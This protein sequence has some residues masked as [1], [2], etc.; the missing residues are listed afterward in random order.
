[1]V[2]WNSA[3]TV[4]DDAWDLAVDARGALYVA[5][6][7]AVGSAAGS[8]WALRR[9]TAAGV[10]DATFG[11]AGT[12]TWDSGVN[13]QDVLAQVVVD[14]AGN[15]YAGGT[16]QANGTD[17]VVRKYNSSGVLCD[18]LG[19]CPNWG[20]SGMV[21]YN[22]SGTVEDQLTSLALAPTGQLY[23]GGYH[24]GTGYDWVVRR[25]TTAG[26]LDG[27]WATAGTLTWSS[28]GSVNDIIS[29]GAITVDDAGNVF[30]AG[31]Q[32]TGTTDIAV[33]KYNASGVPCDGLGACPNWG[34]S[35]MVTY[36][37]GGGQ[38]SAYGTALDGDGR[39]VVSGY[40]QTNGFDWVVLRYTATGALD[41]TWGGG[42]GKVTFN[43]AAAQTDAPR[44]VVIDPQ[45]NVLVAG[46]S[47]N[48]GGDWMVRRYDPGG[49]L[50]DG[51]AGFAEKSIAAAGG[52][53]AT[54]I[55]MS[56]TAGVATD[57]AVAT[58]DL[59]TN[60]RSY[61]VNGSVSITS[62][63]ALSAPPTAALTIAGDFTNNGT[64][65][66]GT[67]TVT[68]DGAGTSTLTYSAATTFAG[69]TV[70][71][72][73][74]VLAFDH[75]DQTNV[76]GA[77]TTNGGACATQ[78]G[79]RSDLAGTRFPLNATG[80]KSV[81]YTKV[82]D[83]SA[84][85]AA[86]ATNASSGGNNL[87]WTIDMAC[88]QMSLTVDSAAVN[89][90]TALPTTDA[91]GSTTVQVTTDNA[92]GY[93]LY[94]HDTN[95]GT[96]L[97]CGCGG[98]IADWSGTDVTP[99]AWAAGSPGFGLSV[100]T[101]SGGR[102]AKWGAAGPFPATDFVNNRYLGLALTDSLLH[103]HAGVVVGTDVVEATYRADAASSAT[104]GTYST[105]VTY[106]AVPTP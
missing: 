104:P 32:G 18:G 102:M 13:Q 59:A 105:T 98:T 51:S 74:K 82:T 79:L 9:Y 56:L 68:F 49:N 52:T 90:G 42:T 31:Y 50:E 72:P 86:S 73:S 99:T 95:T 1:M 11:T 21:T 84:V 34:T 69:L 63:G 62:K 91:L 36:D 81:T 22:T 40:Q 55:G 3:G 28:A 66:P 17:W 85:T 100:R 33:R 46:Y 26:T 70:A 10:L 47:G 38:D 92:S 54:T 15:V 87:G 97:A 106:T 71:T 41:T 101:A 60:N 24:M 77:L 103:D 61:D 58:L 64:F 43:S 80:A 45:G 93:R 76:T 7:T 29:I 4:D 57:P 6:T 27:T 20:T 96:G 53:A 48:N 16:M 65:T 19:A 23:A 37:S 83:S 89:L 44:S 25:Y 35:G 88:T 30:A 67:G 39:L 75:V 94:A 78:V 14:T 5:G 8:N 12:V 2:T